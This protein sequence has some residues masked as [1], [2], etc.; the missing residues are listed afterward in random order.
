MIKIVLVYWKPGQ[1][2][3]KSAGLIIEKLQV[4]ITAGAAGEFSSPELTSCTDS[5]S[6]FVPSPC[7]RSGT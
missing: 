6:V 5:Y 3:C 1:L 4:R 2:V 7:Y